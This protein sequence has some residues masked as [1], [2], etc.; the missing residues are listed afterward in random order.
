MNK[1]SLIFDNLEFSNQP[2][3]QNV[4][5]SYYQMVCYAEDDM[6]SQTSTTT[7]NDIIAN[8]KMELRKSLDEKFLPWITQ[9]H[10]VS[11]FLEPTFK[12]LS[13]VGDR[14]YL[15]MQKKEI[16]KGLHVLVDDLLSANSADDPVPI[17]SVSPA[18]ASPKRFKEDPFASFRNQQTTVV[19]KCLSTKRARA[20]EL[21]RQ[22]QLYETMHVSADYNNNPL[23]FWREQKDTLDILAKIAK[24]VLVIPASSSESE[25]HF[26][27]AG[28]I[29]T[30]Q[31]SSLDSDCVEALVVLK[32]AYLNHMWP[33]N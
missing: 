31:R 4:V 8:L 16:R 9:L 3:I 18:V 12:T 7:T 29:V 1:F 23:S 6:P 19:S 26:S 32:E 20:V 21:D 14:K 17:I 25:R 15:E 10:W 5:P 22:I 30:E 27:I 11:T 13:F 2:T 28:Q 24:S 33:M